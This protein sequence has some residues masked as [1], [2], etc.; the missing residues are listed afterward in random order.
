[1]SMAR[2][3][4]G[5]DTGGTKS[6][7]LVADEAGRAVGFGEGGPGNHEMIGYEGLRAVLQQITGTALASAGLGLE[8]IAGAGFGVA[9]YDWPSERA[10]TLEAI[11]ALGLR[12]PVEAVNDAIVGLVAGAQAGWGVAVVGGTGCNCWGWDAQHRLGRVTG[13][14][15]AMGE[16]GGASDV[17]AEA[18]RAISRAWSRRGPATALTDAFV[19]LTGAQSAA[20]LLEGLTLDRYRLD[21]EA[22][23]LVFQLAGQG[24][25]V[26]GAIIRRMGEALGDLAAGVIRQLNFETETFEVV[27]VGSLFNGGPLLLDP[28]RAL[29]HSVAPRAQ[30]VRLSAPPVIGGVLLGMQQ[31]GWPTPPV[32]ET[33]AESARALIHRAAVASGLTAQAA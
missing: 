18:V 15:E 12:A 25:A 32:R 17:V 3:F 28:M 10:P 31:A 13:M 9:G 33:L 21:A 5:V 24:D 4:L 23:P 20:N 7:A 1:M 14:G 16:I 29:I 22:A 6:H 2:Y 8:H 11:G 19:R 27:L 26:A 30:L